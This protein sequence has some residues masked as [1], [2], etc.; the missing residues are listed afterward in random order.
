MNNESKSA[1]V[2]TINRLT[3]IP[4]GYPLCGKEV[5]NAIVVLSEFKNG[6]GVRVVKNRYKSLK[7]GLDAALNPPPIKAL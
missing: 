5:Q 7:E 6:K 2:Q 4:H 1:K 3:I